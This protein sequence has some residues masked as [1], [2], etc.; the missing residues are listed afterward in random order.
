MHEKLQGTTSHSLVVVSAVVCVDQHGVDFEQ[1]CKG[2]KWLFY[3]GYHG[4]HA[5][6]VL[7]LE[8]SVVSTNKHLPENSQLRVSL[9]STPKAFVVTGAVR[10]LY[11]LVTHLRKVH[12]QSGLD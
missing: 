6:P 4:Q 8:P 10:S 11:S 7:A 2:M 9:H 5:L 12:A 3:R 1:S